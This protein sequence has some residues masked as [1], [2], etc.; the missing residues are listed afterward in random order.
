M[1]L[2]PWDGRILPRDEYIEYHEK[3]E[4]GEV[5]SLNDPAF[6]MCRNPKMNGSLHHHGLTIK[7]LTKTFNCHPSCYL[8][9]FR[10]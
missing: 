7:T 9:S 3:G 2:P 8:L 10:I 6:L 4:I 1:I 5:I